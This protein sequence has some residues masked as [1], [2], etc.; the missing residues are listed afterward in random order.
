MPLAGTPQLITARRKWQGKVAAEKVY[1]SGLAAIIT[2]AGLCSAGCGVWGVVGPSHRRRRSR[3]SRRWSRQVARL[4]RPEDKVLG[5]GGGAQR[6]VEGRGE[7]ATGQGRQCV[8][9][10]WAGEG[11]HVD[12]SKALLGQSAAP[13]LH[14][15]L[16]V[17][18]GRTDAEC[19]GGLLEEVGQRRRG[20]P[21]GNGLD[22]R[23]PKSGA[24][25]R[26]K[27][28][29]LAAPARPLHQQP[30]LAALSGSQ[31]LSAAF[32]TCIR[33]TFVASRTALAPLAVGCG[34]PPPSAAGQVLAGPSAAGGQTAVTD[35][36]ISRSCGKE[37]KA[38]GGQGARRA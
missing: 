17:M 28:P 38:R 14:N 21:W 11:G 13:R 30:P 1:W 19:L 29:A 36:R 20:L 31:R 24:L 37:G 9:R 34:W 33:K 23:R 7:G 2:S 4:A 5:R 8:W 12:Q 35:T 6:A 15:R 25:L 26:H 16:A 27:L 22:Q 3:R 10:S 18:E 32:F